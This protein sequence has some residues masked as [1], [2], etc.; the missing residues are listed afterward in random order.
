M[1]LVTVNIKL[2]QDTL[3]HIIIVFEIINKVRL[4]TICSKSTDTIYIYI[5]VYKC[6]PIMSTG[7]ME[8]EQ[9]ANRFSYEY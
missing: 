7:L 8:F 6:V 9:A 4:K 5:D 2:L 1:T 3:V